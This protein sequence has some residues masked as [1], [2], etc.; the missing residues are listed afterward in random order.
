MIVLLL[1]KVPPSLRGEITRWMV[2][3]KTG[4]FAGHLSAMVR[5]KLWDHICSKIRG[6]GAMMLYN[7]ANEQGYDIRTHGETSRKIRSFDGLLL[8]TVPKKEKN[9]PP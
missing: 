2:E 1:E 5:D 8:A 4:V 7:A 3:L 9:D 6:G